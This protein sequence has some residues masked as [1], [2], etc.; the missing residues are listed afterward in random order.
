MLH[1]TLV[2]NDGKKN[3]M[4]SST[5][6]CA[7]TLSS[8][9]QS[10]FMRDPYTSACGNKQSAALGY[11]GDQPSRQNPLVI[12][13]RDLQPGRAIRMAGV[14]HSNALGDTGVGRRAGCSAGRLQPNCAMD[15]RDVERIWRGD[16]WSIDCGAARTGCR[17]AGEG[18]GAKRPALVKAG[19]R[20]ADCYAG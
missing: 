3:F 15:A 12:A 8:R 7:T 16:G 20:S 5:C 4:V 14:V 6:C 1:L 13:L 17:R 19:G 9:R 2:R 18:G 11:I 10:I